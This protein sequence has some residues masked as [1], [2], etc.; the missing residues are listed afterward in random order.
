[1]GAG[2]G[3]SEMVIRVGEKVAHRSQV[4]VLGLHLA[5]HRIRDARD[6]VHLTL[7]GCRKRGSVFEGGWTGSWVVKNST[8]LQKRTTTRPRQEAARKAVSACTHTGVEA[9]DVGVDGKARDAGSD[10]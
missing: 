3:K 6:L 1:M 8:Q 7:R 10:F 9:E 5:N 4:V 2:R